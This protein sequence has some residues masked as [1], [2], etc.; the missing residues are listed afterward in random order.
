MLP[1][2]PWPNPISKPKTPAPV[3]SYARANNE[4]VEAFWR[5]AT[6]RNYAATTRENYVKVLHK[7]LDF[8]ASQSVLDVDRRAVRCFLA[9]HRAKGGSAQSLHFLRGVLRTFYKFLIIGGVAR[10]SPAECITVPKI[11]HRLPRCLSETEVVTILS[12]AQSARDRAVLE[13]FYASG[14]RRSELAKLQV[15]DLNLERG[16]L[17]VRGGKGNKDRVGYFGKK[18]TDAIRTH[19]SGREHGL[20]F[21]LHG[22]TAARIVSQAAK[23]A[24]IIGVHTH[25]FRHAFATHLLNRGADLR[26][27]QELLGHVSVKTT[28][29]YT[30]SAIADLIRVHSKCHPRGD[31]HVE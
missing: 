30:H 23:R 28:Q 27:V 22:D 4:L 29:I 2:P 16:T 10:S 9:E 12:A 15:S 25:T 3:K 6:A 31:A 24:G 20:L 13:L 21:H 18:A 1:L 11:P 7:F 5:Y 19:L 26:Y 17:V 8:I 14:L